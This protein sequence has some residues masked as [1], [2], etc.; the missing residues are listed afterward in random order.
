MSPDVEALRILLALPRGENMALQMLAGEKAIPGADITELIAAFQALIPFIERA[1]WTPDID[2]RL[3]DIYQAAF[4]QLEQLIA[5]QGDDLRHD[6]IIVI[7]VADRPLHLN[8]CL[9]SL[10]HLCRTYSYGGR[11]GTRYR[12][13][14]VVIADDSKADE[15]IV[16]NRAIAARFRDEGITIDYFGLEEQL[17]LLETLSDVQRLALAGVLGTDGRTA[18]YHKGAS[19]MRNISYLKL[20][21]LANTNDHGKNVTPDNETR[22]DR[23]L[24]CRAH[25]GEAEI[26]R[27]AQSGF[28][29]T[30]CSPPVPPL[31]MGEGYGSSLRELHV[32]ERTLFYFIDSDQEFKIKIT[33][34]AGDREIYAINFFYYLDQVFARSGAILLTGK[35]VGDPPVSP[36]VM[37]GNFLD[38][39]IAFLRQVA[40]VSSLDICPFHDEHDG[41]NDDASYHDMAGLFGF[42]AS[43]A[44]YRY[45]CTLSGAHH[46]ADCLVDFSVRLHRFFYGEHPTR[47]T[48]YRF[49]DTL[50][51][52][53]PARTVYTGNYVLKPEALCYFI[54]FA[55]LRLRMAGP[56]LGRII[57][58]QNPEGFICA[59]LPMLHRRT[60]RETGE[61]EFRPGIAETAA[62]IDLSGEFERQFYGDVMLFTI[63]KLTDAGFPAT[64]P[65]REEIIETLEATHRHLYDLY[66]Q[67]RQLIAQKLNELNALLDAP[68][69]WWNSAPEHS[70]AREDFN[71][72]AA[73]I[74]RNFDEQSLAAIQ[75]PDLLSRR[76]DEIATAILH[77]PQ[78]RAVW[79]ETLARC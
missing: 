73:N 12:K 70:A 8:C 53:R 78:D 79:Q 77:Y 64:L 68:E 65:A 18:F 48:Y 14:A 24:P 66:E 10:L 43:D 57:R 5:R 7:P 45:R 16:A 60:V 4:R 36:A 26:V 21:R 30:P 59:N 6:F 29:E 46:V 55:T 58:A 28:C 61:A 3:L 72:F 1:M 75:A 71:T 22:H 2:T 74:A 37:A 38:D 13:I 47:S 69:N 76:L 56:V 19:L 15:N 41:H 54:P 49:E 32:N 27:K 31:P 39:V 63:E 44:A 23:S 51:G 33:G 40:S 35:V 42:A 67:R 9:E 17:E 62:K 25:S 50:S 11:D 34:L 20:N 52:V